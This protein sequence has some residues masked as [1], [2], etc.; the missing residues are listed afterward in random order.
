MIAGIWSPAEHC[1]RSILPMVPWKVSLNL[2]PWNHGSKKSGPG[3]LRGQI[4]S[5]AQRTSARA[6]IHSS[7]FLKGWFDVCNLGAVLDFDNYAS[8]SSRICGLS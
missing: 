2:A 8:S 1:Y 7:H 6:A 4:I 3:F 5:G